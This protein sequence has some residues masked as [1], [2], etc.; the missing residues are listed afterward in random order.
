MANSDYN[1]VHYTKLS[2][3]HPHLLIL[4][5][6]IITMITITQIIILLRLI[7][8]SRLTITITIIVSSSMLS[9]LVSRWISQGLR[10]VWIFRLTLVYL[11]NLI[12]VTTIMMGVVKINGWSI[13]KSR[14]ISIKMNKKY[15]WQ[16]RVLF[17]LLQLVIRY[18]LSH[19][20]QHLQLLW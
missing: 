20:K 6:L 15:H 2:N 14:C 11:H 4:I 3:Y 18:C 5:K 19:S 7:I 8:A 16:D 10:I 9:I 12:A 13:D 1:P 17:P